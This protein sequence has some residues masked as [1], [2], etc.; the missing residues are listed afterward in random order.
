MKDR[1]SAAARVGLLLV[2]MLGLGAAA[3]HAQSTE[4]NFSYTIDTPDLF[5]A[6]GKLG[7]GSWHRISNTPCVFSSNDRAQFSWR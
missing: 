5:I 2:I 3:A 6:T 4:A 7:T 1:L